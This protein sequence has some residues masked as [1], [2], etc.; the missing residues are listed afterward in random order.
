MAAL[1][2]LCRRSFG[3]S[4]SSVA[5][6]MVG[7]GLEIRQVIGAAA[8]RPLLRPASVRNLEGWRRF[9]T[10]GTEGAGQDKPLLMRHKVESI[11]L[12]WWQR[13]RNSVKN[14]IKGDQS[15]IVY[16][17]SAAYLC[18]LASIFRSVHHHGSNTN[19]GTK[20]VHAR[21]RTHSTSIPYMM[22][23]AFRATNLRHP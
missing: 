9:S 2:R 4:G 14:V 21:V 17:G 19:A 3:N 13:S 6:S 15:T 7:R 23:P 11:L 20:P 8:T 22:I 10:E 18:F 16:I 12:I 1:A 5:A